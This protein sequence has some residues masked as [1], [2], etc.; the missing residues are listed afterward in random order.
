VADDLT[1]RAEP[2]PKVPDGRAFE[3]LR[4]TAR[5][6]LW[7]VERIGD[8]AVSWAC[9]QHLGAVVAAMQRTGEVTEL[10]VRRSLAGG[11]LRSPRPA[12]VASPHEDGPQGRDEAESMLAHFALSK[13]WEGSD[14]QPDGM[15]CCHVCCAPCSSLYYLDRM[16][17]LDV[18][19]RGWPEGLAGSDMFVDGCVDRAWMYRQWTGSKVQEQCGHRLDPPAAG[20]D[21]PP[22]VGW[23]GRGVR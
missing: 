21:I 11:G 18:V 3:C 13:L 20:W 17:L 12:P 2:V 22:E 8:A 6:F 7:R 5:E 15:G 9:T 19:V 23:P 10:V 14:F 1:G 16:G 4:C